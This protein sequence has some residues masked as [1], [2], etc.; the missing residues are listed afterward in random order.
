M[1]DGTET[2]KIEAHHLIAPAPGTADGGLPFI[3]WYLL[4]DP[5]QH[6]P[7]RDLR[8]PAHPCSISP[9]PTPTARDIT[10]A[11]DEERRECARLTTRDRLQGHTVPVTGS[12]DIRAPERC[13]DTSLAVLFHR[14]H[15][16][17]TQHGAIWTENRR[18]A[19]IVHAS[20]AASWHVSSMHATQ[21]V[22][23]EQQKAAEWRNRAMTPN[24]T[25]SPRGALRMPWSK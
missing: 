19:E 14:K 24:N 23:P 7:E 18:V 13:V 3:V 10:R 4:Q 9:D 8:H 2:G 20:V 1:L 5:H 15:Q 12:L 6:E 17:P 11:I 21:S 22:R 16:L 25:I